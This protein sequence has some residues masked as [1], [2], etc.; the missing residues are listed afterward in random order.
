MSGNIRSVIFA[1]GILLLAILKKRPNSSQDDR[2]DAEKRTAP[3]DHGQQPENNMLYPEWAAFQALIREIHESEKRHQKAERDL[4]AAQH[5]TA[6]GLNW[7]TIIGEVFSFL[8]FL[9]IAASVIVA[10]QAGEDGHAAAVA[11]T[12]SSDIAAAGNRAWLGPIKVSLNGDISKKV[13]V[14]L[15]L[16][17][18]NIGHEPAVDIRM[19][20]NIKTYDASIETAANLSL[21]EKDD[22]CSNVTKQEVANVAWP[23]IEGGYTLNL[24][25]PDNF[26]WGGIAAGNQ[27]LVVEFCFAYATAS[28]RTA[29]HHTASCFF[30]QKDKTPEGELS[31][32]T[33]GNHVD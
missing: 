4:G 21:I 8:A 18:H 31:I 27:A 16:P 32:C 30:Y 12:K 6:K 19:Y 5:R 17:Y 29:T 24:N 11:A 1:L 7:I 13:P 25:I 15:V 23:L 10:R 9:A 3:S 33:A 20:Y 28:D 22:V 2:R 26:I 14:K